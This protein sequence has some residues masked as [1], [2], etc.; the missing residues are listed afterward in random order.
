MSQ[1]NSKQDKL[2]QLRS[3]IDQIDD[4]LIDLINQRIAVVK[5]V[6]VYKE[7]INDKFF[8]RSARE[9]DMIKDLIRKSNPAIPQALIINI[10]RKMITCA[11]VLEQNLQI[12][13]FNP[14]EIIDYQYL[15]KEYYGDFIAV[16]SFKNVQ[17]VV[18]EIESGRS[19]IAIFALPEKQEINWW[20]NLMNQDQLKIYA[21]IPLVE[22]SGKKLVAAAIKAP[23]KSS[24][25]FTLVVINS[26]EKLD[27]N[28]GKI[29]QKDGDEY[30]VQIDG[31]F[32]LASEI[33]SIYKNIKIIGHFAKPIK[34]L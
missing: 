29:L 33:S 8:V 12:A 16:K 27:E 30:L 10:W 26:S 11:N 34:N 28:I 23:E 24:E 13:L 20:S 22:N 3:K 25:D 18:D 9:A 4:S 2:L 5:E 15:I 1:N 6:G 31:F 21:L 14:D 17:E 7:S 19:Q 32:E